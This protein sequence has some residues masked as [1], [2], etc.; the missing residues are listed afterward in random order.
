MRPHHPTSGG[1]AASHVHGRGPYR[2]RGGGPHDTDVTDHELHC[3]DATT[4]LATLSDQSASVVY[5]DP[6]YGTRSTQLG[7]RDDHS[8][9][10]WNGLNRAVLTHAARV[11]ARTGVVVVS[12]GPDKLFDMAQLIRETFPR[13]RLTTITVQASAGVTAGGFREM[14]EYLLFITPPA[15]APGRLPWACGVARSPW[16]GAT[17]AT[18][19]TSDWPTEVYPVFV[20]TE[21]RRIVDVGASAAERGKNWH[22]ADGRF[23][24]TV[25]GQ[26]AGTVAVWPVTRHGKSCT[27]RITADTFRRKLTQ[28]FVKA[29]LPHMPGNPNPFSIKHLPTGVM[30]RIESGEITIREHDERGAAVFD[31]VWRPAGTSIPTMWTEKHHRTVAGTKRLDDLLGD[32]HGFAYPKPVGL[33][34]DMLCATGH[35]TGLVVDVFA[36]SGSLYDAVTA[37]GGDMTYVGVTNHENWHVARQRVEAVARQ[38][39]T[40][41]AVRTGT[42]TRGNEM[43]RAA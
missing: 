17:L 29:D 11:I 34:S 3:D 24:E 25:D 33:L 40:T 26:P 5:I 4:F 18:S 42:E 41:I 7:Y 37:V 22:S 6:P 39:G 43:G 15:F 14:S 16:E 13:R 36:G 31:P 8:T 10:E 32:S 30:K 1:A 38:R 12:I 2:D 27:W 21:T 28:G 19:G 35:T 20:D 9:E 23:P